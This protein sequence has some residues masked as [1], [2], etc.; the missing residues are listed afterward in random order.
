MTAAMTAAIRTL[1][2]TLQD[3]QAVH[4]ETEASTRQAI[5]DG[6]AAQRTLDASRDAVLELEQA[7]L[8]L[9]TAASANQHPEEV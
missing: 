7:I 9:E 5:A 4:A 8:T 2:T 1:K 3:A 6:K